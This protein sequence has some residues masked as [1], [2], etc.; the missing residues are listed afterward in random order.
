MAH[1]LLVTGAG[2][3]VGQSLVECFGP[4]RVIGL[5]RPAGNRPDGAAELIAGDVTRPRLGLDAPAYAALAGR[6]GGV[7]HSAALTS[8]TRAATD[9]HDVNATGTAHALRL[10]EDAGVPFH[11]I[12]TI[13]VRR[14]DGSHEDGRARPYRE[15][16]RAAEDTVRA[17]RVPWS[18]LRM[19]LVIG[20][21]AT[22]STPRFQ[23]VYAAMKSLITGGAPVVPVAAGSYVDFLPRDHVARSVRVLVDSGALGEHWIT[24]GERAL[25]IEEFVERCLGY[26][27]RQG[28]TVPRPRLVDSE[29]VHRL[30][31]PAF[32]DSIG[33]DLRKRL[34]LFTDILGPLATDRTLPRLPDDLPGLGAPP[35][36]GACLDTSLEFF[37]TRARLA[38]TG[39]PA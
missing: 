39:T 18:I 34:E 31:I 3:V 28:R 33:A 22:G 2:G 13:Y 12:S 23:G 24:A 9:I 10:A 14:R 1:P 25:T 20:D 6:I 30:I 11:L 27:R 8:F 36:L 32:G 37:G 26:A 5:V 7:L 19:S 38:A 4:G 35:D 29:M 15:S 16:K 21:S 17:A